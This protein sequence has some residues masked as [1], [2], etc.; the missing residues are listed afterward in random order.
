MTSIN[1]GYGA[2]DYSN[3]FKNTGAQDL[4][5]SKLDTKTT[6]SFNK[7][8]QGSGQDALEGK[9]FSSLFAILENLIKSL[10]SGST[11]GSKGDDS[12]GGDSA[13]GKSSGC[14]GSGEAGN[15]SG[16]SKSDKDD[17]SSDGRG[18]GGS[19]SSHGG[20]KGDSDTTVGCS[21]K[22]SGKGKD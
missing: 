22:S 14:A 2:N 3:S 10:S 6:D 13:C 11:E 1:S 7:N 19:S 4:S 8:A 15:I 12:K 20:S 16:G 9:D 21:N 5:S 17:D 18:K